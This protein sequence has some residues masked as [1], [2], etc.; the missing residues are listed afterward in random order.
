MYLTAVFLGCCLL[1]QDAGNQGAV[2]Q[3]AIKPF[4]PFVVIPGAPSV[5]PGAPSVLP[6]APSVLPGT[7]SMLPGA[8]SVLP[9]APSVLPAASVPLESVLQRATPPGRVDE[10]LT[11]PPESRLSGRMVGLGASLA[12]VAS[13]QQQLEVLH[14]YW[15]L[16]DA[17]GRYHF[18]LKHDAL[19]K[20]LP[21]PVEDR[22]AWR[23]ALAASA[24]QLQEAEVLA[25]AAQHE[26]AAL[27][28]LPS[29]SPLPL[30]ADRPHVGPYRTR[31]NE[32]FSMRAAPARA[33]LMQRTLPI[34][35]RA[36]DDRARA[37][38]MAEDALAAV[39][40]DY[41]AGRTHVSDVLQCLAQCTAQR[42]ALMASVCRYNADIADY[43]LA[44]AG[45]TVGGQALVSMLIQPSPHWPPHS[46][47]PL[48]PRRDPDVQQA[49]LDRPISPSTRDPW[50]KVPTR[51]TRPDEDAAGP[52]A[53][54]DESPIF[55]EIDPQEPAQLPS[56][57]EGTA[58]PTASERP[59]VPVEAAVE[60]S[61]PTT[62]NKPVVEGDASAVMPTE[63]M[64]TEV[65]PAAA[66]DSSA[67]YSGLKD[68]APDVRVQQLTSMLHRDRT[69]PKGMGQP[70]SL[71]DCLH[72]RTVGDRRGLIE[73]YWQV[74][75]RAAEYQVLDRQVQ[76]L[77][78]LAGG[79]SAEAGLSSGLRV[80]TVTLAAEA[81]LRET[82]A[83]LVEAQFELA[84]RMGNAAVGEWPLP[85]TP[86]HSGSYLLR[87]ESPS[88][89][90][91]QSWP[92][93]RLAATIPRLTESL[94]RR[95]TAVVE[96]DAARARAMEAYRTEG[97]SVETAIAWIDRQTDQTLSLLQTST[98]YNGAIAE[99]ALTVLPPD[100]TPDQLAATLTAQ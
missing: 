78:S 98:D 38:G 84:A 44:V 64:P 32:L 24:A 18:A 74:R 22:T 87:I 68:I 52:S 16:A 59:M 61:T 58:D 36:I 91:A 72:R 50:K 79:K 20:Q 11:L 9:G 1:G 56:Q 89:L 46:T 71:E 12:S 45:P 8:P 77:R 2:N 41:Q 65:M 29:D 99:Y 31:F 21:A 53:T 28:R 39:M 92:L 5:L 70:I 81:D 23:A 3:D 51:A 55:K 66:I 86:P 88:S 94:R 35:W 48:S 96:A 60:P 17:V 34:R 95:A 75:Q 76:W 82:H 7:P 73:R 80:R 30:P 85:S 90:L 63:V 97:R 57:P 67:L 4:S 13:R 19:L 49:G 40:T 47:E 25:V 26:L 100:I 37:V 54:T 42:Q 62:L 43:A 10:A 93:R 27:V 6:A 15:R 69:L 14:A 83:A 33:R